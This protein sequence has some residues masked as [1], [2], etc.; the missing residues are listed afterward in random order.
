[1]NHATLIGQVFAIVA[2]S[3]AAPAPG[4][5]QLIPDPSF[6]RGVQVK[7]PA[8][9]EVQGA[10]IFP[11]ATRA[12]LL[13]SLAQWNSKTT[14]ADAD[15]QPL[16]DDMYQWADPMKHVILGP[17]AVADYKL[18]LAVNGDHEYGG[19]YRKT[20]QPWAHLLVEQ[21]I[22][23]PGGEWAKR[24]P[25]LSE[26][27]ALKFH[28]NAKLV[29]DDPNIKPG[30][31]RRIHGSQFNIYFTIQKLD[32][33]DAHFGDYYW[34][35]IH[36]FD[37][38]HDIP[39]DYVHG[40]AGTGKLIYSVGAGAFNIPDLRDHQWHTLDGD[41]LSHVIAGLKEAFR[42]DFLDSDIRNPLI[43]SICAMSHWLC[44]FDRD[45]GEFRTQRAGLQA[46][47]PRLTGLRY[48]LIAHTPEVCHPWF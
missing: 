1:M 4:D 21:N 9:G 17:T 27:R 39:P 36:L 10:L 2:C 48:L 5:V 34:F 29:H 13:W 28:L 16:D 11:G 46:H 37:T 3:F 44:T 22:A 8:G 23:A 18:E 15:R 40:D 41:L 12:P 25:W 7:K 31:D 26:V 6:Q 43:R 30:F 38:R 35:G 24:V 45:V 33:G 14:L 19:V 42:R 32:P 47:T 20:G